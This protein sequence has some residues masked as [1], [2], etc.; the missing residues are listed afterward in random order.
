MAFNVNSQVALVRFLTSLACR[1]TRGYTLHITHMYVNMKDATLHSPDRAH[2]RCTSECIRERSHTNVI[3]LTVNA[4][5]LSWVVSSSTK[6][7]ILV[8]SLT[9]ADMR[10]VRAPFRIRGISPS[11]NGHT[12][13]RNLS[14]VDSP[15][16]NH[17][18]RDRL[19][20]SH[21]CGYIQK[22][23]AKNRIRSYV[24]YKAAK[25]LFLRWS[26]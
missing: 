9:S 1:S 10:D 13:E 21:T 2:L 23:K 12:R 26:H 3:I 16:V 6:E 22:K 18:F 25:R 14:L 5:S 17:R 24:V 19:A 8:K 7:F 4:A 15:A 20:S 11:T